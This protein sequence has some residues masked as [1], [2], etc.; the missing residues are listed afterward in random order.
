[1]TQNTSTHNTK[2]VTQDEFLAA[3]YPQPPIDQYLELR[4]IPPETGEV[5][6]LWA[7]I[8]DV[9]QR[10]AVLKQA[11]KLNHEG[12]GVYYAPCLRQTKQGKAE[13]AAQVPALWVDIDC[14]DD[15]VM[16]E[17][18]LAA[19]R[20]FVLQPSA[21][22]DSGGGWHA[23]W[24]LDTPFTLQS[25]DDRQRIARVLHGL[26]SALDG[27]PGY[28]KSVASVM[29]LPGSTNTKPGRNHAPVAVIEWQ[30]DRRYPLDDFDWLDVTLLKPERIGKLEVVTLNGNGHHTLPPRTAAYLTSGASP[31][32]RN[33]ELFAAACQLRDAGYSQ[34][35]AE[36]ELVARYLADGNGIENPVGREKEARAT[37]ASAFSRPPREP[38]LAPKEH[39]RQVVGQLVGQYQV[40]NKPERP[41]TQQIVEAVEACVHLNPVEWAEERAR[42]KTVCGDS[43]KISDIDRLYKEKKRALD[44]QRQQEYVD[45]ESYLLLDGKIIYRKES[46]RGVFEKTV[47]DWAATA[48]YQTC[49]VDDDGKESHITTIQLQRGSSVK[50]LEVPGEVFV[51]DVALRRFI[52]ANAGVQYVVRAGM[53][54]HLVP[55]IVQLSGEFP[56]HRHYNFMGWMQLAGRW[57]YVSPQDSITATGKLAEP[58]SVELDQRLRDYGLQTTDWRESLA[59]FDAVAKVLPSNLAPALLA[60]ALLPVI[61]RFFPDAATKPAVHL[62]GTSGSGKSE[63]ASLLSSFYGH[64]SRDTPPA[65]WGDTIN[66]VEMLGYPLADA[67]YWVDDYKDIYA[68][69]RTFTRFMQSYSRNLGRGRLTREAKLQT[70]RP[71][72]GL[73]L[74]TGETSLERE[75]SVSS[76]M[77][78]LEI[79]PWKQRDPGGQALRE[80]EA[81]REKLP[82]FTAHLASWVAQQLDG[83]DFKAEIAS[84]FSQNLKGYTAK[85]TREMGKANVHDRAV[86]NWAVL[87]T[88]YQVL[89]NFIDEIDGDYLLPTW[90]DCIVETVRSL[91]EERA[92]EVFRNVLGQLIGSGQ[93]LIEPSLR[94]QGETAPGHTVVGYRDESFLYLLPD[95]ALREVNKVQPLSFSAHAIGSQLREDGLLLPGKTN[96][97]VQKSVRGSVIRLWRLKPAVLGCEGCET[98]EDGC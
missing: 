29:R 64:F 36:A 27:D 14:D 90:Q 21:I 2:I 54:K 79:P 19:L 87:V 94:V 53:S 34:R 74:S 18:G 75:M 49:Q 82:G 15:P 40:E 8:R 96:L 46:Y 76:R 20:E 69:T 86:K 55:A 28:V 50:K 83:G 58:P 92:S 42:L 60:F 7:Q 85:V 1:M 95:V 33:T 16:R 44:Q 98:C 62:V 93:C 88:V 12:Y 10:E 70:S 35:D 52:G 48:L 38:I 23:Y 37:I 17:A 71:C 56:T 39:A 97:T 77:M 78:A 9:K 31:E 68:D 89:S 11:E 66:M 81:L 24:L 25:D 26:F 41:T 80:A 6:T 72:R 57:V 32:Q 30:P 91:R 65:Q 47:A 3:L 5:R 67:L 84:R 59:A 13:S 51:D 22:V 4:C 63:I 45:S 43:L 73:I 61:Q